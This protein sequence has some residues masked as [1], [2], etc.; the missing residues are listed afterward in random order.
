MQ[1]GRQHKNILKSSTHSEVGIQLMPNAGT[2]RGRKQTMKW[3]R[4]TFA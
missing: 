4:F 2:E 1:D 3:D